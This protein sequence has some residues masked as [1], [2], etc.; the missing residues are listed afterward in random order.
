MAYAPPLRS[1]DDS[2][3]NPTI[4]MNTLRMDDDYAHFQSSTMDEIPVMPPSKMF[5]QK[6]GNKTPQPSATIRDLNEDPIFWRGYTSDE[7]V[8]SPIENDDMSIQSTSTET[9]DTASPSDDSVLEQVANSSER[10]ELHQAK[11]VRLTKPGKPKLVWVAKH[12]NNPSTQRTANA[13]P[14]SAIRPPTS[15][16][17]RTNLSGGRDSEDAG[18]SSSPQSSREKLPKSKSSKQIPTKSL[19]RQNHRV[20]PELSLV[21]SKSRS[22]SPTPTSSTPKTP[23]PPSHGGRAD[24]LRHDPYSSIEGTTLAASPTPPKPR[25]HKFS[26]SLSLRGFSKGLG[27]NTSPLSS[28]ETKL[29]VAKESEPISTSPALAEM[30]IPLWTSSRVRAKMVP[31]GANERAPVLVLPSC[32]DDSDEKQDKREVRN[33]PLRKD[34]VATTADVDPSNPS[35]STPRRRRRSYSA[36]IASAKA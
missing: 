27:R 13:A 3:I 32:P 29:E 22:E 10:V 12:S 28:A 26:S 9:E 20:R 2:L 35:P 33:W 17:S 36:A 4:R 15:K 21:Q 19:R 14:T 30:H 25:L 31:R 5:S 24:F 11:A 16:M 7:E 23:K 1:I 8:A 6:Y 18:R 34:S